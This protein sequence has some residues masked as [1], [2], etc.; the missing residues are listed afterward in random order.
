MSNI[1]KR[2]ENRVSVHTKEQFTSNN[3]PEKVQNRLLKA[4]SI[5]K[6]VYSGE[7]SLA[8]IN[9]G[10]G[11]D[12]VI[13]YIAMWIIEVNEFL[14]HSEKMNEFQIKQ[15]ARLIYLEYYYFNLADINQIFNN[16]KLG[17][18]G[19][20][21]G[22]LDGIK[23]LNWF[24]IYSDER[25]KFLENKMVDDCE[26]HKQHERGAVERGNMKEIKELMSNFDKT[27]K[28]R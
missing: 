5:D 11:M 8:L 7:P 16:A 9:K 19:Q 17:L 18:Y 27:G 3:L 25:F 20:I 26:T 10:Y 23:I 28:K 6:A 1:A 14:T 4:N 13:A 22:S 21:F 15:T 24:R 2:Q 12:Y